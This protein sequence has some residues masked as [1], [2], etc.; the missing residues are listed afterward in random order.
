VLKSGSHFDVYENLV[1]RIRVFLGIF[2]V[3]PTSHQVAT[4]IIPI[5]NMCPSKMA[6]WKVQD[7]ENPVENSHKVALRRASTLQKKLPAVLTS[8]GSARLSHLKLEC[9]LFAKF[10]PKRLCEGMTQKESHKI[11]DEKSDQKEHINAS[12]TVTVSRISIL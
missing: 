9:P 1:N 11:C 2:E 12:R 4:I 10:W 3:H 5:T 7:D 6:F 8:G